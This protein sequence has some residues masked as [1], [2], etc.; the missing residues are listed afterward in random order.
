MSKKSK[1]VIREVF[2]KAKVEDGP[3]TIITNVGDPKLSQL[4]KLRKKLQ[5][6]KLMPKDQHLE[7]Y[8]NDEEGHVIKCSLLD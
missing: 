5:K 1:M 2:P 8:Y 7:F 4:W 6:A 3:V